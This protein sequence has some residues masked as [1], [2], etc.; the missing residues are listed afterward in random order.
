MPPIMDSQAAI[1]AVANPWRQSVQA[2]IQEI[3]NNIDNIMTKRPHLRITIIWIPGYI[4]I[5]GNEWADVEAKRVA[6][7]SALSNPFNQ[8]PLKSACVRQIKVEA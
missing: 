7:Q 8:K 4:G 5:K 1:K 6:T 3:L 2:I